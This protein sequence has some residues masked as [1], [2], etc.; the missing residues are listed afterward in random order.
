MALAKHATEEMSDQRR[1][2]G[3]V[4]ACPDNRGI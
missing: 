3:K 2:L 4:D 1:P